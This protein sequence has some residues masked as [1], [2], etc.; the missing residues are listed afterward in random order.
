MSAQAVGGGGSRVCDTVTV[1]SPSDPR[2]QRGPGPESHALGTQQQGHGPPR[3][4]GRNLRSATQCSHAPW[5]VASSFCASVPLSLKW[6]E[7][8]GG[9][10]VCGSPAW[11]GGL[12]AS[13]RLGGLSLRQEA[14][15]GLCSPFL[16]SPFASLF[17]PGYGLAT[18]SDS[19][20]SL[21]LMLHPRGRCPVHWEGKVMTGKTPQAVMGGGSQLPQNGQQEGSLLKPAAQG[22]REGSPGRRPRLPPNFSELSK[23]SP[24]LVVSER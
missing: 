2:P 22:R 14:T 8:Q 9:W 20:E 18:G 5:Q 1:L 23:Q 15:L 21:G 7:L 16:K 10:R 11:G 13:S 3:H 4:P 24:S 6:S 12:K 19:S 17:K